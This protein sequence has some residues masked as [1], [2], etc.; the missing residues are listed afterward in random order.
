MQGLVPTQALKPFIHA[1]HDGC[2]ATGHLK[3]QVGRAL[4]LQALLQ[5]LLRSF[6]V[7]DAGIGTR[8]GSNLVL[9][10]LL[11]FRQLQKL[12]CLQVGAKYTIGTVGTVQCVTCEWP[13]ALPVYASYGSSLTCQCIQPAAA[14]LIN[15]IKPGTPVFAAAPVAWCTPPA[16]SRS[17]WSCC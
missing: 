1:C 6:Q 5:L 7:L 11:D 14:A 17:V 12:L 10:L 3:L 8:A 13:P 15:S 9:Q 2:Y 16:G 4:T